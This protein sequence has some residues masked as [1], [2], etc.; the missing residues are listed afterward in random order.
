VSRSDFRCRRPAAY[1]SYIRRSMTWS[2]RVTGVLT[3]QTRRSD[4]ARAPA[5][6]WSTTFLPCCLIAHLFGCA[7]EGWPVAR[8]RRLRPLANRDCN[9]SQCCRMDPAQS[10]ANEPPPSE[11]RRSR[12]VARV[13]E[14]PPRRGRGRALVRAGQRLP[15]CKKCRG[16]SPSFCRRP[17]PRCRGP[18]AV[19]RRALSARIDLQC[20]LMRR[21]QEISIVSYYFPPMTTMPFF[22]TKDHRLGMGLAT[23]RSIVDSHGGRLW[24]EE[25]RTSWSDLYRAAIG[26]LSPSGRS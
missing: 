4:Q 3:A 5:C 2:Q 17:R 7:A 23:C 26:S 9:I 15:P 25:E 20:E 10:P 19:K 6:G 12:A 11:Q 24:A 18:L 22:T 1:F 8:Y 13:A 21:G 16:L 14:V